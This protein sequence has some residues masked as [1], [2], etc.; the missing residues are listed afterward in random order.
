MYSFLKQNVEIC[1]KQTYVS[2]PIIHIVVHIIVYLISG[3]VPGVLGHLVVGGFQEVVNQCT[4]M[5]IL[6]KLG[7][8][9]KQSSIT[10]LCLFVTSNLL[11]CSRCPMVARKKAEVVVEGAEAEDQGSASSS[12]EKVLHPSRCRARK[13]DIHLRKMRCSTP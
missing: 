10:M 1:F 7:V 8:F 12:G 3:G 4:K 9:I 13:V 6:K 2:Y 11:F 5:L